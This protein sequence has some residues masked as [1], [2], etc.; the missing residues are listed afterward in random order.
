MTNIPSGDNHGG[1]VCDDPHVRF[2]E[3]PMQLR[4]GLLDLDLLKNANTVNK[5]QEYDIIC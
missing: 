3:R 1:A 4:M 2:W 5:L